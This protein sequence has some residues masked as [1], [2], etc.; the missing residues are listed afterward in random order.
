MLGMAE[1]AGGGLKMRDVLISIPTLA[2]KNWRIFI[3]FGDEDEEDRSV[4]H[5]YKE[6]P[7]RDD[8]EK[9]KR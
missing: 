1:T 2:Y 3:D 7:Y 4:R 5:L 9:V 6:F 8:V